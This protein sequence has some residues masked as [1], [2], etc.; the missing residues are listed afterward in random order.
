[1]LCIKYIAFACYPSMS[2]T[3]QDIGL[4]DMFKSRELRVLISQY[5]CIVM[6]KLLLIWY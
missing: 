5:W 6:S 3:S 4:V 1:M 2:D